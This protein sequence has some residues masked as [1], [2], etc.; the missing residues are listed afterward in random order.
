MLILLIHV[1]SGRLFQGSFVSS[2]H[3]SG[4]TWN[5]PISG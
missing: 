5:E 1:C 2:S 3:F 4:A